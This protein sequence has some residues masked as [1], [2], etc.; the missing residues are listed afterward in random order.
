MLIISSASFIFGSTRGL[1]GSG[2]GDSSAVVSK[3]LVRSYIVSTETKKKQ[4]QYICAFRAQQ[5][6]Q[7]ALLLSGRRGC[8][9]HSFL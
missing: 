7:L 8:L 1:Y 9:F 5:P 4:K 2:G 3:P 6:L